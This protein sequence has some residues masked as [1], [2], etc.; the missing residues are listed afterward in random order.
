MG[1]PDI[2]A[3]ARSAEGGFD[4]VIPDSWLQ[5]RTAYGGLS[6]ALALEAA[7]NADAD[8][9]PLRSAQ[10]S[11]IGPLAGTI[12]IRA[13]KLRR[14]RNAAFVRS[15]VSGEAGIGL[16]ATFVFMNAM[17]SQVHLNDIAFPA[18]P[19]PE[20]AD[21]QGDGFTPDFFVGNFDWRTAMPNSAEPQ[22]EFSRWVKLKE[23][24]GLD[25]MVELIAIGDALPPAA[26]RLFKTPAPI[27]TMT[28]LVNL[29]TPTPRTR[30]GWWLVRATAN[31]AE[32][33][34]SSQSM[35]VWNTDG[36]PIATAMQSVALF[37]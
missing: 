30:D 1:L 28:W 19:A 34:C 7:R 37:G 21:G 24:D 27:S 15:D 11:Y 16:S 6:A 18:V 26:M 23:R 12:S 36:E 4:A 13:Q 31:Y 22:A 3:A 35:G 20:L 29:L 17:E 8:L 5:G 9:P 32:N 2:I 14:G 33:G 25:P 10:I